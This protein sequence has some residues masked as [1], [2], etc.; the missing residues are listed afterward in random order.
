MGFVN[1]IQASWTDEFA[2]QGAKYAAAN[3]LL[4]TGSTQRA[5]DYATAPVGPSC[6]PAGPV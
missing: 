6:C 2:R 1:Y 3:T 5:C 4:F